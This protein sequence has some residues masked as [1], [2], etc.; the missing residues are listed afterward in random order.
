M[1]KTLGSFVTTTWKK[2]KP[3]MLDMRTK[4]EDPYLAEYFQWLAERLEH[5]MSVRARKPFYQASS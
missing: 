5:Q 3:A 2:Y 1:D 4:T